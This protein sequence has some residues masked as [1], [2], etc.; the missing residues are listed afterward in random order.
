MSERMSFEAQL[1]ERAQ[2]EPEFRA[3]LLEDPTAAVGEALGIDV[4]DLTIR[5]VEEQPGE[6]IIVLPPSA[7]ADDDLSDAELAS[8]AGGGWSNDWPGSTCQCPS[9]GSSCQC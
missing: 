5:V 8:V 3:R 4:G 1:R 2:R 6:V 7:A 9:S